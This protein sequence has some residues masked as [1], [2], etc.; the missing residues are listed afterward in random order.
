MK[1]KKVSSNPRVTSSDR[2]VTSSNPWVTSSNPRV[3]SSNPRV[4]STNPRVTSSRI[5]KSMKTQVNAL[6]K[7]PSKTHFLRLEVLNYW[8]NLAIREATCTFSFWWES[9]VL[10]FHCSMAKTSAGSWMSEH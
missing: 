9:L 3:T 2:R 5:I 6:L 4:K 7:Q 8:G 10:R 1:F